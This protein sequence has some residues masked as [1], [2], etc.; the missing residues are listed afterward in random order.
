MR[1]LLVAALLAFL[2]AAPAAEAA[3]T[4]AASTLA[5]GRGLDEVRAV[6]TDP[7]GDAVIVASTTSDDLH[8]TPGAAATDNVADHYATFVARVSP[9]GTLGSLAVLG[10][11]SPFVEQPWAGTVDSAGN[12]YAAGETAAPNFPTTP[13]SF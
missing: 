10:G 7:N 2:L 1:V 9:S 4:L 8:P 5:G 12:A 11:P 13:G 3:E 6:G